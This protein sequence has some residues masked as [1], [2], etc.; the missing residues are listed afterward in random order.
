MDSVFRK[1]DIFFI[2]RVTFEAVFTRLNIDLRF[3][4]PGLEDKFL[5][6]LQSFAGKIF[7][8]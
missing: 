3:F 8:H 2:F 1:Q 4:Y 7:F 6:H 5:V